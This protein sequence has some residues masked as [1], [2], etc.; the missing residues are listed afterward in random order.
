[1]GAHRFKITLGEARKKSGTF[2]DLNLH[3]PTLEFTLKGEPRDTQRAFI[4]ISDKRI[5]RLV[6]ALRPAGASVL[7]TG[8]PGSGKSYLAQEAAQRI[9]QRH[10]VTPLLVE[11]LDE[12][13]QMCGVPESTTPR[14]AS[15]RI[16]AALC[17]GVED[18]EPLLVVLRVDQ[19]RG[20]EAA[21][22]EQLVRARKLRIIG[23]AQQVVGAADRLARDPEVQLCSVGPFTLSEAAAFVSRLLH[24]EQFAPR[25]LERWYRATLGN[26]HALA[27]LALAAERR[28]SVRRARK[29]A[30]VPLREDLAP[31]D[32]IAQ[33]GELPPLERTTLNIV[34]LAAPLTEPSLL[35]L[36]DAAAVSDLLE[37]QVLTVHTN[38][39]S[40]TV[41]TTRLPIL[42]DALREGLSPIQRARLA[43]ACFDAL[44]TEERSDSST[45]KQ[46]IVRLGMTAG[47]ELP[48]DWV[49]QAMRA[50]R[51]SGE[52]QYE[53][54]LALA[55]MAHENSKRS[56]E[57]ILRACD[58]A[59]FLGRHDDLDA[60]LLELSALL[61][62]PD[63]FDALPLPMQFS[64]A[65]TSICFTPEYI[66]RP[67]H[68]LRELSRWAQRWDSIGMDASREIQAC[69]MRVL[70]IHGRQREGLE[71]SG[72][73]SDP[74]DLEA[75]WLSAP[76]RSFEALL[77]VQRGEFHDALTIAQANRRL[78]LLHE[79]SPTLSGDIEG[80]ATF[81]AHWARGTTISAK[82]TIEH[83]AAPTR[84]D[85]VAVHAHT[86][87]IDLAVTLFALQEA[88]WFD[89][90]DLAARLVRSLQPNDPLGIT[91]FAHAAAALA[92]A[93]L[94]EDEKARA[95]L[96][97]SEIE[98][99][100]VALALRGFVQ[101]LTMQARHWLRDSGLV[102]QAKALEAWA[103]SEEIPLIE[104][105]ALD[106]LAHE[107][108][109]VDPALLARAEALTEMIDQPIGGAILAHI[110]TMSLGD[111]A[112]YDPEER[113]LSE[114]GI[115]MP[116]PPVSQ[117]T[118]REREIALYTALGYSS[119]HVAER[120]HLSARTIETHLAHI[121]A[122]LGVAGRD[123][124]RRWFANGREASNRRVTPLSASS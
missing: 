93:A 87:L 17:S 111:V 59:H 11:R 2:M 123:D 98:R 65:V 116:L 32:F 51:R 99:P 25:T 100:G 41:L 110:Q 46:R 53:L 24:A 4:D 29:V 97:H 19:Y 33:L 79:I 122:K 96:R 9:A 109:V 72:H 91:Q 12:L 55:A 75:A 37:R 56:A 74:H 117:L 115:W 94:G 1:M 69:R 84:A 67:A 68:A 31:P 78:I 52:F 13:L 118:G 76:A 16:I 66:G 70:S 48:V 36:L 77:R 81:L 101:S 95:A 7:L 88:R 120:L 80:F 64:L 6:R 15:A 106:V 34:A 18:R 22:L 63:R 47:R 20:N 104:L 90:A 44:L 119:K 38:P 113:L 107:Q 57:A 3:T 89:A 58:L 61:D 71:A 108:V 45:S 121:Y 10:T 27:T 54:R 60:A 21:L 40:S 49:W 114:L 26:P 14:E 86:G 23:T 82:H 92:H 112:G 43:S 102:D 103:R 83:I 73:I 39:D 85:M 62:S 124:L 5:K 105:R 30:W 50:Q 28:G 42:A 35:Q 8:G